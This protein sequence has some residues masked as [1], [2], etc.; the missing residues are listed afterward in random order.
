[1][2]RIERPERRPDIDRGSSART[3]TKK[4]RFLD[5]EVRDA[6]QERRWASQDLDD[7]IE[8]DPRASRGAKDAARSMPRETNAELRHTRMR[9]I[10]P[11]PGQVRL[12]FS[13]RQRKARS[14]TKYAAQDRMP[15]TEYHAIRETVWDESPRWAELND[16]LSD[17]AGDIH[18]DNISDELR[19]TG[20]RLDRAIQRYERLNDRG[21]VLYAQARLPY[22]VNAGNSTGY[23]NNHFPA[24]TLVAFDRY[25][26]ATHAMHELDQVTPSGEEERHVVLEIQTRRGMYMGA[27]DS[28][29]DTR[30]L[31]PRGL[32]LEVIGSHT[33]DYER[34]DGTIGR[35][36]V[37]QMMD[38]TGED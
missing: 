26:G 20:Q 38:I 37:I 22:Y 13:S 30:H 16:A 1:M 24:G 4:P 14:K 34:P 21:H 18:A 27:S 8:A 33:A 6:R 23:A 25:T 12:P 19:L 17:A 31:L 28:T 11:E 7:R 9:R 15:G 2:A 35:R 3:T 32:E 5:P 36:T 29:H 10:L